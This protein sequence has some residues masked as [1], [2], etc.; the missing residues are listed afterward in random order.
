M[1]GEIKSTKENPAQKHVIFFIYLRYY[2]FKI[3]RKKKALSKV[4]FGT[5]TRYLGTVKSVISKTY[6][7]FCM[8]TK[9]KGYMNNWKLRCFN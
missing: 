8:K 9:N 1:K 4:W 3:K 6:F 2:G 5:H 7:R